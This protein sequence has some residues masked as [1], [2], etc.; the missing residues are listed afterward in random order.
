MTEFGRGW[1]SVHPILWQYEVEHLGK[2]LMLT[3]H[4]A[5][6]YPCR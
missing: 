1:R 2:P 6:Y 3:L 4:D 5:L